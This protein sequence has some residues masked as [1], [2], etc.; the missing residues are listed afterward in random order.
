MKMNGSAYFALGY[1]CN[2]NCIIC[3]VGERKTV[4][5]DAVTDNSQIRIW[6]DTLN[7]NGVKNVVLSGGEPTMQRNLFPVLKELADT[8][9]RVTILSNGENFAD[10]ELASKVTNSFPSERLSIVTAFHAS[11]ESLHEEICGRKGSF[12]RTLEGAENI[13]NAG[14]SFT[15]KHCIHGMNADDSRNF[16]GFVNSMFPEN[17]PLVL[18][19]IDYVGI[20]EEN[21]EKVKLPWAG[22]GNALEDALD[23]FEKNEALGCRR[24]ASVIETPLCIVDPYYWRFF[25]AGASEAIEVY[26]DAGANA[27]VS[28][29]VTGESYCSKDEGSE[30]NASKNEI[31]I[32]QNVESECNTEYNKC[33]KC[34]VKAHCPGAWRS[35]V[36]VLSEDGLNT[37]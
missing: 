26:A 6:H 3:P 31:N 17:V 2:H 5:G 28:R 30:I 25:R 16:A 24:M 9:I 11:Y 21:L 36:E 19:G 20:C 14:I 10:K 37:I 35:A 32:S 33:V 13:L 8:D 27:N 34:R 12:K 7:A 23:E 22:L 15:V 18:C 1:A 29:D 4:P